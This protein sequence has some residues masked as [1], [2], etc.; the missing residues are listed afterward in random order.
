MKT[1]GKCWLWWS[2]GKDSAWALHVLRQ[3]GWEIG[4]LITTAT[5]AFGRVAIHGTRLEILEAQ[6][7][8]TGV[9]LRVVPLPYPC[10]FRNLWNWNQGI[11]YTFRGFHC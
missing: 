11:P 5:P 2:S 8:S 9:A 3:Q 4:R 1:R 7:H 10:S 6:A